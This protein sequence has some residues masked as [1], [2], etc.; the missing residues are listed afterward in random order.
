M[1]RCLTGVGRGVQ[2]EARWAVMDTG[3]KVLRSAGDTEDVESSGQSEGCQG[4]MVKSETKT[5][6]FGA[7]YPG[8]EADSIGSW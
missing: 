2:D 5:R 3:R 8:T 1:H 6:D 7:A 4:S